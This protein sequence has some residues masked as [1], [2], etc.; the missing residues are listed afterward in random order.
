MINIGHFLQVNINILNNCKYSMERSKFLH[1][2]TQ[3]I[4]HRNNLR[5]ELPSLEGCIGE[6][7]HRPHKKL[8]GILQQ[9]HLHGAYL[10]LQLV[11][12]I[13]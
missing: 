12:F 3:G 4:V 11:R 7:N 13:S 1:R 8:S 2:H 6:W 5:S 9:V 10:L